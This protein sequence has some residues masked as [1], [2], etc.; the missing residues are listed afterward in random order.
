MIVDGKTFMGGHR[1]GKFYALIQRTATTAKT[2]HDDDH[3]PL[4]PTR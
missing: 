4:P 1:A 2:I 3:V